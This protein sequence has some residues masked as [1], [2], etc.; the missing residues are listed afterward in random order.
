MD[1]SRK[2]G[3]TIFQLKIGTSKKLTYTK[4]QSF[5]IGGGRSVVIK[6]FEL[7]MNGYMLTGDLRYEIWVSIDGSPDPVV[8]QRVRASEC[9][10]VLEI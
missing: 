8:W 9:D 10:E 5:S 2:F 6:G 7:D 4:G 3:G 1:V